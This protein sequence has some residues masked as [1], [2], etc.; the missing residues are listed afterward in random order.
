MN[1][2][3][4]LRFMINY[5]KQTIDEEDIEAVVN[6]LRG[7]FLTTGPTI[8]KFEEA[9][10]NKVGSKYAVAVANGTAALHLAVLATGFKNGDRLITTPIT[11]SAS[12]NCA[13]YCGGKPNFLDITSNGLIDTA[14]IEK[15]IKPEHKIIIPVHYAGFV[16]D[17]QEISKIAK[18]NNLIIIEDA[19]HALGAKLGA[20]N[21]GSCR[22][23][24]MSVFSF[25]PVKHITT[26]EGGIITTNS[27]ELYEKLLLL[28]THGITRNPELMSKN[29]GPWYY[30]MV[31]LGYNYRI[32]DFQCAL[33][34]SQLKKIDDF[35]RKRR[36]IAK[37]Y[38]DTLES[39]KNFEM[40]YEVEPM[41]SSYH[42]FPILLKEEMWSKKV[43]IFDLM[44][45]QGIN[46]QVHYIPVYSMPFYRSQGYNQNYPNAERFYQSEISIP[47]YPSLSQEQLDFIAKNIK[48]IIG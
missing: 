26:G 3:N 48:E 13:F 24:D 46:F 41:K 30:E 27:K 38:Y 33:G 20:E 39:C 19:C 18:E 4:W 1:I 40:I 34:L 28:R 42:L 15:S 23:S 29:D 45:K 11:F 6:V 22:Y 8:K 47:M 7:D 44:A 17:M 25:H 9:F 10:A 31:T 36:E 37:Y 14:L 21:V 32:T 12:A 2:R 43:K 5:G 35:V 16:C